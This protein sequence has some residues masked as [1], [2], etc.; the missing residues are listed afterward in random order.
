MADGAVPWCR[1]VGCVL[2]RQWRRAAAATSQPPARVGAPAPFALA[3]EPTTDAATPSAISTSRPFG[4]Q[5]T[6]VLN[7]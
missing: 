7:D 2:C 5:P 3:S 1:R 6:Q 4:V